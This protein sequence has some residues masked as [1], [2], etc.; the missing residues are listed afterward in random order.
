MAERRAGQPFRVM[1]CAFHQE[2]NSF[3][4][5]ITDMERCRYGAVCEGDVML[6]LV[7]DKPFPVSG[8][9]QAISEF[10]SEVIPAYLLFTQSGGMVD[11][12]VVETFLDKMAAM[13][14]SA[15]ALDG[16][17]VTLH[18]ATQSTEIDDV[19]GY[20]LEKL[21][22]QVPDTVIVASCDLH[23]NVTPKMVA[24]ADYISG[25]WT[26][27]HEDLYQ[28]GYRAAK[29]G[30][31][32]IAS[33]KGLYV[34]H[35]C[36]SMIVPANGYNTSEGEFKAVMDDG[37]KLVEQGTIADFS[38]FQMQ[39]WLDVADGNSSVLVVAEDPNVAQRCA[40]EMVQKL[41][42]IREACQAQLWPLDD[43]IDL[44]VANETGKPVVLVDSS[45]STNAGATGDSAA[46]LKRLMERGFPVKTA[47]VLDDGAAAKHAMETGVG[48][49]GVFRLGTTRPAFG[50]EAVETEAYVVS[51]H[52]GIFVQEGP[53]GKGLVHNIGPS[54]VLRVGNVDVLVCQHAMGNGDPQLYRHFG[55]EPLFYDMV[56]VKACTSFRVAYEPITAEIC[57]ADTPGV[58]SSDICALP[59]QK[60]NRN[61]YPF[62]RTG[63]CRIAAPVV[64]DARR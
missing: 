40:A 60:L 17:F 13:I 43:V 10:G 35:A 54:A 8:M 37:R 45:D 28:T 53:A 20:I 47:F 9:I 44:A 25:Y 63:E 32:H 11:H 7:E 50:M 56:V 15:P 24:N 3:N 49:K 59:F 42:D 4:P 6:K 1:V 52:D 23:A 14:Q 18:G 64:K 26:Y 48:R 57:V 31:E 16:I 51:L 30:M 33:G 34:A 58:A 36:V 61:G 38:V 5:I 2:T 29:L 62:N 27:P 12:A 19:C 55:I 46:V 22:Q 41:W 39:P 21:R